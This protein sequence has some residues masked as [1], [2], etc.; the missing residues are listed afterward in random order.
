VL[1]LS[2]LFRRLMLQKLAAP[3]AAGALK[4]FGTHAALADA[5]RFAEFLAPLRK[6]RWS[7]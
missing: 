6:K 5:V 3:H 1:V 7:R 2:R 4:F